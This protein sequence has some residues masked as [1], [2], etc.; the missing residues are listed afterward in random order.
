VAVPG[1]GITPLHIASIEPVQ[2]EVE[3][4]VSGE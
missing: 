2:F 4:A 3:V 1:E